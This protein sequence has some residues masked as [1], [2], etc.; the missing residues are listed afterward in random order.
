M[1]QGEH[2][3]TNDGES[4]Q[5]KKGEDKTRG[6]QAEQMRDWSNEGST[7]QKTKQMRELIEQQPR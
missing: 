2:G 6:I 3:N 4:E 1:D 7:K 5:V